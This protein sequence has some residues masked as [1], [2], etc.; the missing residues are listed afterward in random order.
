[1]IGRRKNMASQRPLTD[2]EGEVRELTGQDLSLFQPFSALPEELRQLLVSGQRLPDSDSME[3][4][5][6]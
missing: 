3:A 6:A 4:P 5:A 1:M 2:E